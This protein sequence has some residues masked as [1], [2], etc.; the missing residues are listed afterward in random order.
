MGKEKRKMER[1]ALGLYSRIQIKSGERTLETIE[2]ITQNICAGGAY[3][4][5]SDPLPFDACL[6]IYMDF[7]VPGIANGPSNNLTCIE[8]SGKVI[9]SNKNGMAIRFDNSYKIRPLGK[10]T[11]R[12]KT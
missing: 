12:Q 3:F 10:K 9:R 7:E 5:T 4:K 11:V 1:F 2:L 6:S 8:T